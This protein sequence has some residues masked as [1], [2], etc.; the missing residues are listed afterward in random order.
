MREIEQG[1]IVSKFGGT[2]MASAESIKQVGKIVEADPRRRLV[3]VSA[4]GTVKSGDQK[5]TT[6][7]LECNDLVQQGLSF[8]EPFEE[9]TKRHENIGRGLNLNPQITGL[10]EEAYRLILEGKKDLTASLGE[11]MMAE[12]FGAHLGADVV[13]VSRIIKFRK[14]K[15][16][17]PLTYTLGEK[18]RH[19]PNRQ[20][21]P[22]FYGSDFDGEIVVFDRG[23]S[24]I[25]GAII[26]KAVKADVYENW[27]DTDG[28]RAASPKIVDNPKAIEIMTFSEM[29]E[30]GYRG[31][32]ILHRSAVLPA[33]EEGIPIN[34]RNTFNPAYPGTLIVAERE[35][36]GESA[37][38]IAGKGGFVSFQI[39][40]PGMNEERGL[41]R[42]VLRIFENFEISFEHDP[43]GIDT[44]SVIVHKSQLDGKA[45]RVIKDLEEGIRPSSVEIVSGLGLVCVVGQGIAD[46]MDVLARAFNSLAKEGIQVLT[47]IHPTRGNNIVIGMEDSQMNAAIRSL[48]KSLI[49]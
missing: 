10:L 23:G 27:T 31:A 41:A 3:V 40:K 38:A 17:S 34:I 14:D 18:L 26:A 8:D 45:V 22:G 36:S 37:I 29:R 15:T 24:D 42:R 47:V 1:L 2:S 48:Y 33:Q 35:K 11:R 13:D 6:L 4:A 20:V 21:I 25:T 5:V 30:M 16:V 9:I 19:N 32:E 49:E 39:E 46:N 12:I 28:V 43:T 44:M 7:L